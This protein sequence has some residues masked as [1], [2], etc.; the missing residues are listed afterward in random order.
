MISTLQMRKAELRKTWDHTVLPRQFQQAA[1][2]F[3]GKLGD[4]S[5]MAFR[6]RGSDT[7]ALTFRMALQEGFLAIL[8]SG[9]FPIY[10][11]HWLYLWTLDEGYLLT[12]AP[13]DLERGVAPFCRCPWPRMCGSS[14]RPLLCC[15]SPALLVAAPDLGRGVARL[16]HASAWFV[17]A[18]APANL[19][20]SAVATGLEKVNSHLNSTEGQY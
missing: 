11:W 12:A 19:E 20:N 17:A 16:G 15:C 18:G 14:S 8:L 4:K 9:L 6:I 3:S 10:C 5:P 13:P 7:I 1:M 2:L